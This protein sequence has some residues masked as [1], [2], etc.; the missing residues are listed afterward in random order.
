MRGRRNGLMRRA[1]AMLMAAVTM[2]SIL[3]VMPEEAMAAAGP[4]FTLETVSKVSRSGAQINAKISNPSA[5]KV[6]EIGFCLYNA[7]TKKT[8]K[9]A[10]TGLKMR[11]KTNLKAWT[12]SISS[13]TCLYV[14]G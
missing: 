6:T 1:M 9:R 5:L 11:N 7:S 12:G 8:V 4:A 14:Q 3:T 2:I 13:I 10:D